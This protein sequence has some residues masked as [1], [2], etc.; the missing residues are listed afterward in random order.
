MNASSPALFALE[1]SRELG[2]RIAREMGI[3]LARH[4]ER[5][6]EDGEHKTRPLENVRGRDAYVLHQLDGGPEASVNDKLCRLLF[7]LGALRDASA[8]RVTAIIPYLVYARKDRKTKSRDPL[9]SRYIA[10]ILEA[11]GT[12]R[13]VTMDVHNLAAFQSAF[14]CHTDHLS[15]RPLFVRHFAPLL[16]EGPVTVVSPDV[17]GAK[18]AEAL[19]TALGADVPG[20]FMDKKRSGGVV[21]GD[22]LVGPVAGRAAIILDDMISSGTT[23]IRAA[24]ACRAEG[25]TR[26]FAAATH[27]VFQVETQALL[28]DAAVDQV[29]VTDTV[30]PARLAVPGARDKLVVLDAAPLFGQAILRIHEGGPLTALFEGDLPD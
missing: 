28:S 27:G 23:M 12:D 7:F 25:A 14:R 11:V 19:R 17:G 26:V 1:G 30:T 16:A 6:F 4:E 10:Q 21:L 2:S 29:V 22:T 24:R 9:T 15:A 5:G 8:V 18:R 3:D 13:V 20:A